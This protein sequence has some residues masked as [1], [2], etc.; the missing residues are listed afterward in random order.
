MGI[1]SLFSGFSLANKAITIVVIILSIA[2]YS[3]SFYYKGYTTGKEKAEKEIKENYIKIIN[4]T[5][6]E[7][8]IRI[9][10]E[11]AK[12]LSEIERNNDLKNEIKDKEIE[13]KNWKS[14]ALE[15]KECKLEKEDVNKFNDLLKQLREAKK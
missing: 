3:G 9:Q 10:Q 2:A 7:N 12:Y 6:E 11:T 5:Q 14:K 4:K 15:N 13:V 1:F 8:S